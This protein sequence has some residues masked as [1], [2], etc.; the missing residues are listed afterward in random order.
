MNSLLGSFFISR[1]VVFHENTFPFRDTTSMSADDT[2]INHRFLSEEDL[3][4]GE[5]YFITSSLIHQIVDTVLPSPTDDS[6]HDNSVEQQLMEQESQEIN[7]EPTSI[8]ESSLKVLDEPPRRSGRATR[9]LA[10]TKDY[11]CSSSLSSGTRYPLSSYVSFDCLSSDHLCCISRVSEEREPSSYNEAVHDERWQKAM[12]AELK[13]LIDNHTW[14][15]VSLP[16]DRKP[17]GCK[18]VYKIK[19]R[20]DG[21]VERY[22]ARLVAKGFTQ[23]ECFDYH[24][25]FSPVA[26]DVTVRSFL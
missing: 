3:S 5:S 18:W 17:I 9:P 11:V 13:A 12:E 14:D 22:K 6:S 24:E 7:Q 16:P 8:E 21:S 25:T 26:K 19:Y 23:Q 10:L 2:R 1:D 4:T 15:V 20:A